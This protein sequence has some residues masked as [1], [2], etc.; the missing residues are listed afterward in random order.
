MSGIQKK[1]SFLYL[2]ATTLSE[3]TEALQ[4][5]GTNLIFKCKMG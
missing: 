4:V 1:T 2:A 5:L 3:T